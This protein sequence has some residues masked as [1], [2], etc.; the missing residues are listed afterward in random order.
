MKSVFNL[1]SLCMLLLAPIFIMGSYGKDDEVIVP[2][3][4]E[5]I[6]Y[7]VNGNNV[8]LQNSRDT[9]GYSIFLGSH[10]ISGQTEPTVTAQINISFN[11]TQAGV[12][13]AT[14]FY[15]TANGKSYNASGNNVQINVSSFGPQ[16][17]YI[18]GILRNGIRFFESPPD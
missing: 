12:F 5:Y 17:G 1:K 10:W 11:A 16:G 13:P 18:V 6:I 8:T 15:L 2:D 9:V 4:D 3:S 14:N 7:S